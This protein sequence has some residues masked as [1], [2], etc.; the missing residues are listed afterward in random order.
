MRVMFSNKI[1][2]ILCAAADKEML[3]LF[4]PIILYVSS[5]EP[6]LCIIEFPH[7]FLVKVLLQPSFELFKKHSQ[8]S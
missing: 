8:L 3:P 5:S 7:N 2:G 1:R 4:T 6:S